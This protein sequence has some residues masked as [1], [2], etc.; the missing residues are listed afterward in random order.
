MQRRTR[1]ARAYI[2]KI[3]FVFYHEE[4]IREASIEARQER[5]VPELKNSSGIPD[6]T[7]SRAIR[8]LTPL[9]SVTVDGKK[10][11]SP[12]SWLTVIEKTYAWC[13]RQGKHYYEVA[14][15][16][17]GGGYF[18]P[19]CLK[20]AISDTTFYQILERIRNYAALQAAQLNLIYVE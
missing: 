20:L 9:D 19:A 5:K 1:D 11:N 10:L 17:Y 18:R 16:R 8:N 6:P 13:L 7:A 12:E 4:E 15:N 14:K 2:R 3:E